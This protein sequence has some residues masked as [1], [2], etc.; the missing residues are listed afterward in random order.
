MIFLK[1]KRLFLREIKILS[2]WFLVQIT[3]L[4]APY[5]LAEDK[6]TFSAGSIGQENPP[7]NEEFLRSSLRSLFEKAFNDFPEA[8]SKL[9]FL[10]AEEDHPANW[11]LEDE[12]I[13]YL[14]SLRYQVGSSASDSNYSLSE[15][16][17]LFYRIIE[18]KLDYPKVQRKGFLGIR[19]VTREVSLN[20]SFRLDDKS[21]GKVLWFKRGKEEKSDLMKKS[22]LPSLNNQS[23][24]FLSPSLSSDSQGKYLEPALLVAVVGG[25]VY[26][27]FA[28]R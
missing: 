27:F 8:N 24:P 22:M 9:I 15:S 12:L 13:S 7:S 17:S 16:I 14:L 25:L 18:L 4:T 20:L 26:L 19:L 21:T 23:Y 2:F 5:V 1:A 10:K 6:I 11:L 28:N 3:V